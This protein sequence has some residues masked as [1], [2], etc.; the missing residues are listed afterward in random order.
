MT[1]ISDASGDSAKEKPQL[2]LSS[3]V[4]LCK[5]SSVKVDLSKVGEVLRGTVT[6]V[7]KMND[8]NAVL[9]KQ[10]LGLIASTLSIIRSAPETDLP[11]YSVQGRL[12]KES[13]DP[14][15][16]RRSKSFRSSA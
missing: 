12:T 14:A 3:L 2:K 5:E 7:K 11:T 8:E 9:I 4:E 16:S 13:N 1:A 15:F 10:S 6:S